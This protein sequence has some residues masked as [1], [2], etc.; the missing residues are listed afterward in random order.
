MG[1][2]KAPLCKGGS[3]DRRWGIVTLR[4]QA[5]VWARSQSLSLRWRAASSLYTRGPFLYASLKLRAILLGP[6]I[7][8]L[9][10]G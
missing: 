1:N 9:Q 6:Y 8:P 7:V 5:D 3:A 2:L 4:V 10:L